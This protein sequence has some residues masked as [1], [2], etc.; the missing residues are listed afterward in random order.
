MSKEM[1]VGIFF[2]VGM[3]ILGVLTLYAGSFDD[4]LMERYSIRA[5]FD[6][7]DGLEEDLKNIPRFEYGEPDL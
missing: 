7:V 6:K 4:W 5:Y 3:I 1:K 2:V